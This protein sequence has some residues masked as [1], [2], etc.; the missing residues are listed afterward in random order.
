MKKS[1]PA[2]VFSDAVESVIFNA[3]YIGRKLHVPTVG[4]EFLLMAAVKD[5]DYRGMLQAN[6]L[7]NGIDF[8]VL[9]E[10]LLEFTRSRNGD[11]A[12]IQLG[13][14]PSFKSI[15]T[16]AKNYRTLYR[17]ETVELEYLELA[18]LLDTSSNALSMLF[19]RVGYTTQ[20]RRILAKSILDYLENAALSENTL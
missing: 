16:T 1:R 19:A 18:I 4:P 3:G 17:T 13:H 6:F 20:K 10:A 8:D 9:R 5:H 11:N 7:Q 15:V 12:M 2:Q 14:T